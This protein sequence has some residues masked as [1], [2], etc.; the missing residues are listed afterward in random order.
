MLSWTT[1]LLP[2]A[3]F[4]ALQPFLT[5]FNLQKRK[6]GSS[7]NSPQ[8]LSAG[9]GTGSKIARQTVPWDRIDTYCGDRI[10][11]WRASSC[12]FRKGNG[13]NTAFFC[14][15]LFFHSVA[16]LLPMPSISH[17]Y[18]SPALTQMFYLSPAVLEV[19]SPCMD[20]TESHWHPPK[21]LSFTSPLSKCA[22]PVKPTAAENLPFNY[23]F[24]N[25]GL[26]S[27][28]NEEK[29]HQVS[30][31]HANTD[32]C[33]SS[34]AKTLKQSLLWVLARVWTFF[35]QPVWNCAAQTPTWS[36][37]RLLQWAHAEGTERLELKY[38]FSNDLCLWASCPPPGQT[39]STLFTW[40]KINK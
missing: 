30:Y 25:P 15:N 23:T 20:T 22:L 12:C 8:Y 11:G 37:T 33:S 32:C 9:I 27:S 2:A 31:W 38:K 7:Y 19:L 3:H 29:I 40:K 28:K 34:W 10:H 14:P 24:K 39:L 36:F 16:L 21:S 13:L 18:P 26:L 4:R 5:H 17:F 35:E 1:L 6:I